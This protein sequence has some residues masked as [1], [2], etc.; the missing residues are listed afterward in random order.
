MF[1]PHV[2]T[3]RLSFYFSETFVLPYQASSSHQVF[4]GY[5][6]PYPDVS[7]LS[8]NARNDNNSSDLKNARFE[9][10]KCGKMYQTQTGLNLH[11]A[12]HEGKT[13]MCAICDAK[14]TQK[15]TMKRHLR[16]IHNSVQCPSCHTVMKIEHYN[17]HILSCPTWSMSWFLEKTHNDY[18]GCS[19]FIAQHFSVYKSNV[20]RI[21]TL[22][23]RILTIGLLLLLAPINIFQ[24]AWFKTDF[25]IATTRKASH[26]ICDMP[27]ICFI[28]AL[29]Y[30][31]MVWFMTDCFIN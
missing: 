17:Q 8:F 9:C 3:E 11:F 12:S 15:G 6:L 23:A 31:V 19:G 30:S 7:R 13:F 18:D 24:L 25:S 26:W 5:D 10:S 29:V 1:E 28:Q 2:S 14:F 27:G 20:T 21:I 4:T 16:S 22:S